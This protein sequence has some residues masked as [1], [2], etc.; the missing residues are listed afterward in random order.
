MNHGLFVFLFSFLHHLN[1][2]VHVRCLH[3]E[4]ISTG[5][6]IGKRQANRGFSAGN[7][8]VLGSM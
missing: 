1:G 4:K 6:T 8:L 3:G 5:Y 2:Q 7:P